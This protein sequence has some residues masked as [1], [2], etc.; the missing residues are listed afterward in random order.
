MEGCTMTTVEREMMILAESGE[1]DAI[2]ADAVMTESDMDKIADEL[3]AADAQS[4]RLFD[5]LINRNRFTY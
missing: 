2:L 5:A 3:I 4:T 1:L